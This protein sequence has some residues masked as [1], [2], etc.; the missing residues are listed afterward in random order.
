MSEANVEIVRRV[1]EAVERRDTE[2]VFAFYAP[3]IVWQ[4]HTGGAVELQ[5]VSYRGHNAVR[6]FWR[7]WLDPFETFEAHAEMFIDAGDK[8]VVP[9]RASAR[10][11]ASG[12]EVEMYRWNVY[13]ISNGRVNRI[14]V[15]E[16]KAEALEAA[17][18]QE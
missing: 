13:R 9:W 14:D 3:D 7:E 17:G 8:V 16:T 11:K 15:F 5:D 6:Q 10:G 2:A 1:W 4:N 12:A 18:A